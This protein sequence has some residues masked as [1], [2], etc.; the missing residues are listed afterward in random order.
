MWNKVISSLYLYLQIWPKMKSE[1]PGISVMRMGNLIGKKW[2]DLKDLF[3]PEKTVYHERFEQNKVRSNFYTLHPA[4]TI[5]LFLSYLVLRP[6]TIS[7]TFQRKFG[8][9]FDPKDS[10]FQEFCNIFKNSVKIVIS[11]F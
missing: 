6:T 2:R 10:I 8:K 5:I 3:P 4:F 1:N 9:N 7:S 11:I